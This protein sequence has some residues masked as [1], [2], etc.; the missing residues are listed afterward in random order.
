MVF[1]F[2]ARERG[3][4]FIGVH[5]ELVYDVVTKIG[6]APALLAVGHAESRPVIDFSDQFD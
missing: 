5:L 6:E 3:D 4:T 1:T 2:F